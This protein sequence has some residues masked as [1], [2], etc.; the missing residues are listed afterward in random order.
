MHAACAEF[1]IDYE[2]VKDEKIKLLKFF[3]MVA[4]GSRTTLDCV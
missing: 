4:I 2:K 3:S 1:D